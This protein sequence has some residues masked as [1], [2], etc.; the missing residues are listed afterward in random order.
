MVDL[1]HTRRT[2]YKKCA[3]YKRDER[4]VVGDMSM[5]VVNNKPTG[6][7]YAKKVNTQSKENSDFANTFEIAKTICS[8]ETTDDISD[9]SKNDIVNFGNELWAVITIQQFE[10][11]K[12][13]EFSNKPNYTTVLG[14]RK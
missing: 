6:Y 10:H 5:W 14:L 12:E 1:Y 11:L 2:N 3:Y 9:I 7:F 4:S 8:I 13:A